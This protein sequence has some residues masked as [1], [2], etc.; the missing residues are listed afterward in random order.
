MRKIV[1]FCCALFGLVA[2]GAWL[3]Q[4]LKCGADNVYWEAAAAGEPYEGLL[5]VA[6]VVEG[7]RADNRRAWGGDT[8]CG[9]V[10][11]RLQFSWTGIA[12]TQHLPQNWRAYAKA[13]AAVIEVKLGLYTP[14]E[15]L[16]SARYYL[17]PENSGS[18]GKAFFKKLIYVGTVGHHKFYREHNALEALPTHAGGASSFVCTVRRRFLPTFLLSFAK[19]Y[20]YGGASRGIA[21]I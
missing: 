15:Y 14:P 19:S 13:V 18:H 3:L 4:P 20:I 2:F 5:M 1:F 12:A 16:R 6:W 7:R 10:Y 9:V 21:K 8:T 11:K 17:R